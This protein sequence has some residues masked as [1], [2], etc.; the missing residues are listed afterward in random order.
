[1][2]DTGAGAGA[3]TGADAGGRHETMKRR[4]LGLL[5]GV[6]LGV[7][8]APAGCAL[9][10]QVS[11]TGTV[12]GDSQNGDAAGALAPVTASVTCNGTKTKAAADGHYHLTVSKAARYVC[13]ASNP[14]TYAEQ[15]V[16]LAGGTGTSIVLDFGA[17]AN[18]AACRLD[19]LSAAVTCG[20]LHLQ[21]GTLKGRVTF[22]RSITP[23][24]NVTVMCPDLAHFGPDDP[25]VPWLTATTDATG[26]FSLSGLAVGS[27]NCI[28]RS[29][30]D[31]MTAQHVRIQ[32]G[33]V[34]QSSFTL[35]QSSCPPVKYHNGDV[36]HRYSAYLIFWQPSGV[37]FE[38][39]GSDRRY[40]SLIQRY[41]SDVGGTSF[42]GL[43]TQYFDFRDFVQ[44]SA[45][46]AGTWVD[47]TRYQHCNIVLTNCTAA[48]ANRGDPL[49]DDDLH[50]EI[51]RA[52]KANPTWQIGPENEFIVLTGV[53][54]EECFS[55][56]P[57][58]PCTYKIQNGFCGYHSSFRSDLTLHTAAEAIYAYIPDPANDGGLCTFPSGFASPNADRVADSAI[59]VVSHEQ[60]ESIS[61][62]LPDDAPGW[63]DD[64]AEHTRE[65]GEIA[66]KCERDFANIGAD[67]ANVALGHS[68]RYLVQ[69]EWSNARNGC[70]FS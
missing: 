43:L 62:P 4:T 18:T 33:V 27:Y 52:V 63:I 26:A 17:A 15:T 40:I 5:F 59:N 7:L 60:F 16:T 51:L 30:H 25:N 44:N 38:P 36:M 37:T 56:D 12:L 67:G 20:G 14:P 48:A 68:H 22:A 19:A 1:M 58:S 57:R 31:D 23:V 8:V 35:C 46:L 21:P 39:G 34:A 13:T 6:L 2:A 3:D 66:D 55:N 32:P 65:G 61:D 54:A 28:A 45:T 69:G 70:A 24:A 10:Q 42:F 9:Q 50:A 29:S 49:L 41:I 11:I 53:G 47:T 64:V